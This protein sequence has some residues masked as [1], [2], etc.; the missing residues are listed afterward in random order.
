[1]RL[2]IIVNC[3]K[4]SIPSNKY[5]KIQ[6]TVLPT[7]KSDTNRYNPCSQSVA[8]VENKN[9]RPHPPPKSVKS[10]KQNKT[11]KRNRW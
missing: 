1:M 6:L 3:S 7:A 11:A 9:R 10:N 4:Y 2:Q 8:P 5:I